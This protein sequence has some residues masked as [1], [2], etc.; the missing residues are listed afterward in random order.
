MSIT[1]PWLAV[2]G[3]GAYHGVNPAMG[4]LFAVALG[5]HRGNRR[6]VLQSLIAIAIGHASAVALVTTAIV[7]LGIVVSAGAV[8]IIAGAVLIL[9]A[10]YHTLYGSRHRARVGMRAGF[11]GLLLWSFVMAGAHGA[12]L[13]VVP[14]LMPLCVGPSAGDAS[15]PLAAPVIAVAVHTAAMLAVTAIVAFLVYEWLGIDFLRR[16]WVKFVGGLAW[17]LFFSGVVVFVGGGWFWVVLKG[18]PPPQFFFQFQLRHDWSV[19]EL[20][21]VQTL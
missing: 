6:A 1:W 14:A 9:W 20:D 7:T 16:G 10:F 5:L 2:A 19:A 15:I 12:G 21:L 17:A 18:A 8:Q 4:W 11:A 3:L 13:M